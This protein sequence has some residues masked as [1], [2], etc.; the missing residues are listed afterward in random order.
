MAAINPHTGLLVCV[1]I[2]MGLVLLCSS[3]RLHF[4]KWPFHPVMFIVWH[5]YP[6]KIFCAS[7]VVGWLIKTLVT[8]Y[9][10]ASIYGRLKPLMIGLVAGEIP[11]LKRQHDGLVHEVSSLFPTGGAAAAPGDRPRRALPRARRCGPAASTP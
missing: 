4:P 5:T 7:F 11:L 2:G 9:G 6:G 10:G 3:L 1:L 8:S